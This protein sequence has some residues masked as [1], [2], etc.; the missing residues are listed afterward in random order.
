MEDVYEQTQRAALDLTKQAEAHLAANGPDA[1]WTFL[2]L[3]QCVATKALRSSSL[4]LLRLN[5]AYAR[6]SIERYRMLS[7]GSAISAPTLWKLAALNYKRHP[8]SAVTLLT[9]ALAHIHDDLT[10]ALVDVLSVSSIPKREYEQMFDVILECLGEHAYPGSAENVREIFLRLLAKLFPSPV[11]ELI[12][13]IQTAVW[14]SAHETVAV[15]MVH[16]DPSTTRDAISFL[17]R[18]Y[19]E[20]EGGG[21]D[22]NWFRAAGFVSQVRQGG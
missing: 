13:E 19:W 3:H 4:P 10:G 8:K 2:T 16:T 6:Y 15:K 1:L 7:E 18:A 21:A 22:D 5:A 17:A 12:R 11:G 9:F 20:A 14:I